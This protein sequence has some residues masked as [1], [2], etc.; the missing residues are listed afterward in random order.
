MHRMRT[1]TAGLALAVCLGGGAM[2]LAPAALAGPAGPAGTGAFHGWRSAQRAAGFGLIKPGSTYRLP[3]HG[4]VVVTRC[5]ATG[6]LSSRQVIAS[7]GSPLRR[8][9]ALNQN[10]SGGA[11]GNFGAA[12]RLG[13][14]RVHGRRAVLY[15]ACGKHIGP[16]CSSRKIALFLQ[17][18]KRGKYYLASAFNERRSA[19]VGF[20]RSTR[21][22]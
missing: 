8:L 6:K 16:P 14:Y 9:L 4:P 12:R 2:T 1:L 17:W 19:L 18:T 15:G 3:R 10:N 22:V 21:Q 20:A 5:Q 13:S 7:Y 11:C